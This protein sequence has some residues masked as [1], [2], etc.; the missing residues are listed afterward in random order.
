MKKS[1]I[2]NDLTDVFVTCPHC[3]NC[4]QHSIDEQRHHLQVFSIIEWVGEENDIEV[5][6]TKCESCKKVFKLYWKYKED[7][8]FFKPLEHGVLNE[9]ERD[10]N[11]QD[12]TAISE[13]LQL[14]IKND[15][16]RN[17]LLEYL[18]DGEREDLTEG[19]I[20]RRY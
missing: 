13:M 3:K 15:A 18:S 7:K 5:S 12:F 10:F 6:H 19:T 4:E 11:A 8:E 2:D 20:S 9:I 17:I 16:S 1:Y 14:L